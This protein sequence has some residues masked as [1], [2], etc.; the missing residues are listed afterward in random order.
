M[1][2]VAFGVLFFATISAAHNYD[3]TTSS[4]FITGVAYTQIRL[5]DACDAAM[6]CDSNPVYG[7]KNCPRKALT[8]CQTKCD[9]QEDCVGLFFQKHMNGHEICGFY[10]GVD[11]TLMHST[12]ARWVLHNHKRGAV[13]E[14]VPE[15]TASSEAFT[16]TEAPEASPVAVPQKAHIIQATIQ[17]AT[18][19]AQNGNFELA[20][21]TVVAH[22]A[23][24]VCGDASEACSPND[25]MITS[26]EGAS[27]SFRLKV[28]NGQV[29]TQAIANIQQR[30]EDGSVFAAQMSAAGVTDVDTI[31]E[32]VFGDVQ[33][34]P[35]EEP[36]GESPKP[37]EDPKHS[38]M[39][40]M[41]RVLRC[42][43]MWAMLTGTTVVVALL[44]FACRKMWYATHIHIRLAEE[45]TEEVVVSVP[46]TKYA[47][48]VDE[49]SKEQA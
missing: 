35:T 18:A 41:L 13:C 29:A 11:S 25:I 45:P 22:A 23:G 31:K 26:F 5:T 49:T 47:V 32:F 16:D 36:T 27:I 6:V 2:I 10:H 12:S 7:P 15:D 39:H 30:M 38:R 1:R 4:N 9:E 20:F 44:A 46:S 3:C 24:N 40:K 42:P 19:I 21:R 17:L 48:V 8:Y 14:V 43:K 33:V 34:E 37:E 28:T